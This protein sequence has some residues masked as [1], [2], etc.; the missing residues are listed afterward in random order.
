MT[1][2]R[3]VRNVTIAL[4]QRCEHGIGHGFSLFEKPILEVLVIDPD[5]CSDGQPNL[6]IPLQCAISNQDGLAFFVA[7]LRKVQH[8]HWRFLSGSQNRRFGL[9]GLLKNCPLQR[10]KSMRNDC[11]C[12]RPKSLAQLIGTCQRDCLVH[13]I[14][15]RFIF[16]SYFRRSRYS[17]LS[18]LGQTPPKTSPP[19]TATGK[20]DR[21]RASIAVRRDELWFLC[22]EANL[23]VRLKSIAMHGFG[24]NAKS[25]CQLKWTGIDPPNQRSAAAVQLKTCS[26]VPGALCRVLSAGG[27]AASISFQRKSWPQ[28][29]A[30][31]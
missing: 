31:L 29:G 3:P 21:R 28:G 25:S 17:L 8:G 12:P 20:L 11:D 13:A 1:I 4:W 10:C 9:S 22:R 15:G 16:Y 5:F 14:H 6:A 18:R 27:L 30:R 23:R 26:V 24:E 19:Y 7:R 2:I